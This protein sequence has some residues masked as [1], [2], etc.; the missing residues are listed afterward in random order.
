M[1]WSFPWRQACAA[2]ALPARGLPCGFAHPS[3][4]A[5]AGANTVHTLQR[6]SG[7]ERMA[8]MP[9]YNDHVSYSLF[10][11]VVCAFN[12]LASSLSSPNATQ[13]AQSKCARQWLIPRY[14]PT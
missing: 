9:F 11:L 3:S 12:I 5:L 8:A 6:F 2:S 4:A 1:R 14:V 10:Q 13:P 7:D